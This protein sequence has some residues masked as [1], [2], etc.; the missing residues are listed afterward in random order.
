MN[1]SSI[2]LGLAVLLLITMDFK[3]TGR[4]IHYLLGIVFFC[5]MIIHLHGNRSYMSH[6]GNGRWAPSRA[7]ALMVN[8]LLFAACAMT[9]ISG[10]FILPPWL[11][12]LPRLPI[13]HQ[14]HFA[15]AYAMLILSGIHLGFHWDSLWP[16]IKEAMHFRKDWQH[17]FFRGLLVFMIFLGGVFASFQYDV[18]NRLMLV[19]MPGVL[20]THEAMPFLFAHMALFGMYT[21]IGRAILRG[22]R[23]KGSRA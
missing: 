10:L 13:M 7:A 21:I 4:Y 3:L 23:Q 17:V 12:P 11:S 2:S 9:V 6:L 20:K 8:V 18:G 19:R 22:L 14:V 1:R 16:R 5:L 15:A